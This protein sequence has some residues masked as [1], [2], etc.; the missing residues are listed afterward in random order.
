MTYY[1]SLETNNPVEREQDLM[2]KLA[3]LVSAR[4]GWAELTRRPRSRV[5]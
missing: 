2:G 4:R 5:C 3:R 1:D